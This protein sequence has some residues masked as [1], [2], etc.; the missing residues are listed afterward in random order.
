[1]H[2]DLFPLIRKV[3]LIF[4]LIPSV[5]FAQ[6]YRRG[7]IIKN[8][9]DS[10][11]GFIEYATEKKNSK[12]CQFRDTRRGKTTRFSPQ[13]LHAYGFYGDSQFESIRIPG[14]PSSERVFV[15][16]ITK[17]PIH[18]YKYQKEFLVKKDSLI[19]LPTPKSKVIETETGKKTQNDSRYKGLLNFL[20]ADC[21]LSADETRYTEPDITNLINNYN[22]CK[23][24]EPLYKKPKPVFKINY[25]IFAG[26]NSSEMTADLPEPFSFDNSTTIVGGIGVEL[27]SPRIFDRIFFTIDVWY[28]KNL[29]QGYYKKQEG[30][31][32][33][34]NDV[35]AEFTSIKI[36]LGFRYNFLKDVNSPYIKGGLVISQLASHTIETIKER[37]TTYG[38]VVTSQSDEWDDLQKTP[39]GIWVGVGYNRKLTKNLQLTLEFRY[40]QG[41][42]FIGTPI[43]QFSKVKNYNF[44]LGIRF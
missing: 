18:L 42:G 3:C 29:Y 11:N 8:N 15:K 28:V 16:I 17:G 27:S 7:Y 41:E 12:Y 22:R 32:I 44:L 31:D 37:Q 13:E 9:M 33:L 23:G 1:M 19:L 43:Q 10:V 39:K 5:S 26:Y 38:Q 34:H 4:L 6:D 36:P 2:C 20:L 21:K 30:S 24:T 40:D 35:H 14:E 25:N